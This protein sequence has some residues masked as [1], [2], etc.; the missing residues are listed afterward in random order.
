MADLVRLRKSEWRKHRLKSFD[1]C[2]GS[3][4]CCAEL[5]LFL[6]PP[7]SLHGLWSCKA[8]SWQDH[9]PRA[10]AGSCSFLLRLDLLDSK[11]NHHA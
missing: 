9:D 5:L 3:A 4:E 6:P 10:L 1:D 11:L 8:Q 7:D 2:C